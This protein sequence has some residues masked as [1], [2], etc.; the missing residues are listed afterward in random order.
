MATAIFSQ[1]F[2]SALFLSFA[3]TTLSAGLKESLLRYAPEVNPQDVINAGASAFRS[4][5]PPNL[6]PGV[7]LAYSHAVS[8]VF[9]LGTGAIIAA[10]FAT[11]GLGWK[12]VKKAKVVKPEA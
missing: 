9:Y 3:Q 1:T 8:H 7:I 10:F 6:L 4:V 12:S 2:G 5:V 11:W